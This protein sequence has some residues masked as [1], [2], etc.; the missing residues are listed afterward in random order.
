[1]KYF[2]KMIAGVIMGVVF[3]V[4]SMAANSS[5]EAIDTLQK[6]IQATALHC[7]NAVAGSQAETQKSISALQS[8]IQ[9]QITKLQN[10]MQTMQNQLSQEIKQVQA[11]MQQGHSKNHLKKQ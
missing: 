5:Q 8:N 1:M 4:A 3:S 11:E 9:A 2:N 10:E 7:N 6:Q